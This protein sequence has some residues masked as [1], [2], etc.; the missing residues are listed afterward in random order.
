MAIR[1]K[2]FP[3]T[4]EGYTAAAE[5]AKSLPGD[6]VIVGEPAPTRWQ[7]VKRWCKTGKPIDISIW[8]IWGILM[9][10]AVYLSYVAYGLLGE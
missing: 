2:T 1:I 8:S 5:Y 6:C 4:D 10:W 7:R 3:A 9:A